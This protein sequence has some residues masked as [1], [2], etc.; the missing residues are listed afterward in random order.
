MFQKKASLTADSGLT[1]ECN[2]EGCFLKFPN[3][4]QLTP[5]M[6]IIPLLTL[7][8]ENWGS[9]EIILLENETHSLICVH[10]G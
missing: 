2:S 3:I 9:R 5:F 10:F 1:Y 8:E 7:M 4:P 6:P